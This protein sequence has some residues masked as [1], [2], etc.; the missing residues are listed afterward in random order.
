MCPDT[1]GSCFEMHIKPEMHVFYVSE[2]MASYI[3]H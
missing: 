2:G 3:A 1:D